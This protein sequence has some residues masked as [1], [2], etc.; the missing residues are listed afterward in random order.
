MTRDNR[1]RAKPG[2]LHGCHVHRAEHDVTDNRAMIGCHQ[3]E[4]GG[5]VGSKRIDDPAFLVL[6][7]RETIHLPNGRNIRGLLTPDVDHHGRHS[8]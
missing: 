4:R 8:G 1:H 6:A 7:E 5:A 2:T 3:R